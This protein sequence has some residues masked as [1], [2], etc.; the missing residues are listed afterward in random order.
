MAQANRHNC[1]TQPS[2]ADQLSQLLSDPKAQ[3]AITSITLRDGTSIQLNPE[4]Q[5]CPTCDAMLA[6]SESLDAHR[7]ACYVICEVHKVTGT[8]D[9]KMPANGIPSRVLAHVTNPTYSHSCCLVSS[10]RSRYIVAHRW[11]NLDIVQHVISTHVSRDI[12]EVTEM[13]WSTWWR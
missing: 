5:Q 2:L 7:A 9:P 6:D 4:R 1:P 10:C 12:G 11:S 3:N 13:L 8:K